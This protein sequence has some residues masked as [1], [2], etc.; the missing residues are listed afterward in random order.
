MIRARTAEK[1]AWL[2]VAWDPGANTSNRQLIS[3]PESRVRV[4][5][6]PTDEELMIARHTVALLSLHRTQPPCVYQKPKPGRNGDEL[7][8]E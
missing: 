3:Q 5:V 4:Y 6:L 7:H 1:L 8:Q 2:G